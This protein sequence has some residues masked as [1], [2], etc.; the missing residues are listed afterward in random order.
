MAKTTST[1]AT[2]TGGL[3]GLV[4]GWRST[5]QGILRIAAGLLFMQ[6]GAQKLFGALGGFGGTPGG[7]AELFSMMGLAGVV[8]FFGGLLVVVGLM[9]RPVALICSVQMIVAYFM[10]HQPEGGFPI[11][12]GGELAL[13]YAFV[14]AFFVT[15]GPG[16][17]SLDGRLSQ[18]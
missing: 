8:E 14:F 2:A 6:H 10:A 16:S 11:Q 9:T 4:S 5:L 7:T 3:A 12:N 13:L 17:F 18:G 1:N 15:A